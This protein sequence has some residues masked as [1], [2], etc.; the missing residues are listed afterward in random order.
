MRPMSYF[1]IIL[2]LIFCIILIPYNFFNIFL[3]CKKVTY[4]QILL[5]KRE[6]I[7]QKNKENEETKLSGKNPRKLENN[8][9]D[10]NE[11]MMEI[12]PKDTSE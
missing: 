10:K 4:Y 1:Q 8:A 12:K 6:E 7:Y 2:E 5:K 3:L 11:S 9:P